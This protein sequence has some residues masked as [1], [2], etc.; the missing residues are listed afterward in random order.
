[1]AKLSFTLKRW[2][3]VWQEWLGSIKAANP[4]LKIEAIAVTHD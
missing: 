3:A 1:M 4:H 2:A